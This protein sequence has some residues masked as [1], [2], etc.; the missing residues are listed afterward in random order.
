MKKQII[1]LVAV[2]VIASGMFGS[3]IFAE[4]GRTPN[5]RFPDIETQY[6]SDCAE[7]QKIVQ[8][9]QKLNAYWDDQGNEVEYLEKCF[10]LFYETGNRIGGD[11]ISGKGLEKRMERIEHFLRWYQEEGLSLLDKRLQGQLSDE[12]KKYQRLV[13]YGAIKLGGK[14]N[15]REHLKPIVE[16]Y[17]PKPKRAELK[18]IV[19]ASILPNS[20]VQNI[21]KKTVLNKP[22][23]DD[24]F[25]LLQLSCAKG[26]I[27]NHGA[28]N[29]SEAR[30][31]LDPAIR[32]KMG[33]V[34]PDFRGLTMEAAFKS[35][36]YTDDYPHSPTHVFSPAVAMDGLNKTREYQVV[37]GTHLRPN[38][39]PPVEKDGEN[40][41]RLST[42]LRDRKKPQAFFIVSTADDADSDKGFPALAALEAV[43]RDQIDIHW[44]GT[45]ISEGALS[46]SSFAGPEYDS[47]MIGTVGKGQNGHP[48]TMEERARTARQKFLRFPNVG[49]TCVMENLGA[50][51]KAMAQQFSFVG[52]GGNY[53]IVI[54]LDG[55]VWITIDR[56]V[57]YAGFGTELQDA[58]LNAAE[59]LFRLMLENGGTV[60]EEK[61]FFP[62]AFNTGKAYRLS[63]S[64]PK[65]EWKESYFF[66]CMGDVTEI[67]NEKNTITVKANKRSKTK[68]TITFEIDPKT[69]IGERRTLRPMNLSELIANDDSVNLIYA[70]NKTD[71]KRYVA[72]TI[73]QWDR[74]SN[75]IHTGAMSQFFAQGMIE[76]VDAENKTVFV[77][78]AKPDLQ[79]WKGYRYWKEN[80]HFKTW[81]SGDGADATANMKNAEKVLELG[82]KN[83]LLQI[84]LSTGAGIFLNG[85][86]STLEK[87]KPGQI[88]TFPFDT[89]LLQGTA[90]TPRC[91]RSS[92][93]IKMP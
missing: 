17:F 59:R 50:T 1:K 69:F 85:N 20:K 37:N 34:F 84:K 8:D 48:Y 18:K 30:N 78:M 3:P 66:Q 62:D 53:I 21:R 4:E 10:V 93:P 15:L 9:E 11:K 75:P 91:I 22:L 89:E 70:Q 47:S 35:E 33:D 79:T 49:V 74:K 16:T 76:K 2:A 13:D 57:T 14:I 64:M 42:A 86:L 23:S 55:E 51:V 71:T 44:L 41:Y 90:L 32:L 83:Q 63:P 28:F 80:P 38:D 52:G 19:N 25:Y 72:L 73:Y 26:H 36:H 29:C 43:Y 60:P 12:E 65:D 40:Y 81:E 77:R 46:E 68:G 92:E 6:R 31:I 82:E 7:W 39:L 56:A 61:Y 5:E 67:N 45:E 27:C 24:E 88:A 58:C 54:D 87:Y